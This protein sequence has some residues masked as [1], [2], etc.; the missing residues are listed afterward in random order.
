MKIQFKISDILDIIK[1]DVSRLGARSYSED[2]A[3][4]YD[5]IKITSRDEG[6]LSR[7]LEERD[8]RLREFLVFCLDPTASA[9][10]SLDY[11]FLDSE[12]SGAIAASLKVL[13]RK[14]LTVGVL[15]DWYT[16]HGIASS[17]T[18]ENIED[19]EN[20]IV[21]MIRQGFVKKPLQ[22]FGPQH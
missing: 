6:V 20:N 18:I 3:S 22:P 1:E 2:G 7:T 9:D 17:I 15:F 5:G 11:N 19:M 10:D 21:C 4:L 13:L 8:A 16:K 12:V 14:Y